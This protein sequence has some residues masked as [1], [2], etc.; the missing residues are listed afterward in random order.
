M[1]GKKCRQRCTKFGRVCAKIVENADAD[2]FF[3]CEV[4][5]FRMGLDKAGIRVADILKK[6]FR[7]GVGVAEANN[8][9]SLWGFGGASQ[10]AVV[11][12]HGDVEIYQVPIG[13][14]VDAVIARFDVQTTVHGKWHVIT[15]NMHIVCGVNPPSTV[16]R[17]QA[18]TLLRQHLDGLLPPEPETPV[19]RI[20]VGDNNLDSDQVRQALQCQYDKEAE[21]EVFASTADRSG[22]NIAVSGAAARC[23]PIAVGASFK[24]RGMCNESHDAVAVV[25]TLRRASQPAEQKRRKIASP[26]SVWPLSRN[27]SRRHASVFP[28]ADASDEPYDEVTRRAKDLHAEMREY[29]DQR[30]DAYYDP[31][32]LHGLS[33]LLFMKRKCAQPAEEDS[34]CAPQ[35]GSD[36]QHAFASQERTTRGILSALRVRRAFL[37]S[38]NIDDFRHV[39]TEDERGELVKWARQEYERSERQLALQERDAEKG[40]AEGKTPPQ[41]PRGAPQPASKGSLANFL[42]QQKRQRWCRHLQRVCGTKEMWEMLAF[43]G[44]FDVDMLTRALHTQAE[45]WNF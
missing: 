44:C 5:A 37:R 10:P 41:G 3:A 25:V 30:H 32:L 12:L 33:L 4:G 29:W 9:L 40:K 18:V 35:P 8:Y 45:V 31:K 28:D 16:A 6:Q 19:V 14:Q 22:D 36:N 13:R 27:P 1:S 39:L 26:F 34:A 38:K 20:M 17:Q 42:M 11:S 21:W 7:D 43:S 15:S 24:D 23:R 2:L